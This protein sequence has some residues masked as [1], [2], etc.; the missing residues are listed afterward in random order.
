MEPGSSLPRDR[1]G[2]GSVDERMPSRKGKEAE[3]PE[4]PSH[5]YSQPQRE[6]APPQ[7]TV[8][9]YY[10]RRPDSRMSMPITPARPSMPTQSSDEP[11]FYQAS[12]MPPPPAPE[13]RGQVRRHPRPL[14]LV[15]PQRRV[16]PRLPGEPPLHM[17]RGPWRSH[18]T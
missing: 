14:P 16:R 12:P 15:P 8:Y 10:A 17:A 13:Q 1:F 9:D 3:R 18:T 7:P 11:Y 5:A 6:P 4:Y 2:M